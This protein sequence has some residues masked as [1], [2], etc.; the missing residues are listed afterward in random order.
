MKES[1]SKQNRNGH[2]HL[3]AQPSHKSE[4]C[5]HPPPRNILLTKF[6]RVRAGNVFG[7]N[8]WRCGSHQNRV[9]THQVL[10]WLKRLAEL[11]KINETI[12]FTLVSLPCVPKTSS[13]GEDICM[14]MHRFKCAATTAIFGLFISLPGLSWTRDY[15]LLSVQR[16]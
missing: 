14:Y 15:V 13:Q 10:W 1:T 16:L 8:H 3:E 11:H 7:I 12:V 2:Q 5:H 4:Q 6:A 9:H